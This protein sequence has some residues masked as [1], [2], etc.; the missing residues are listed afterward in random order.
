FTTWISRNTN[1]DRPMNPRWKTT[2]VSLSLYILAPELRGLSRPFPPSTHIHPSFGPGAARGAARAGSTRSAR[3][4]GVAD[5]QRRGNDAR[6]WVRI[7]SK[8]AA[9]AAR[10]AGSGRKAANAR[11][12]GGGST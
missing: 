11:E 3:F 9:T 5:V 7:R 1:V 10:S 4:G 8:N 12:M 2:P 6:E